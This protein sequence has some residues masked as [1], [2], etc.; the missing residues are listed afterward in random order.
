MAS[1]AARCQRCGAP[2]EIT[3]ETIVAVCSYCGYPNWT[4]QAYVY[5]IELVPSN[6]SKAREYFKHYLE[7]D[8]DMRKL[9]KDVRL[10]STELVYIPLYAAGVHAESRYYGVADVVLTRTRIVKRGK[11][12]EVETE[13]MTTTVEVSGSLEKDYDLPIIARRNVERSYTE[14]LAQYYMDKRPQSIPISQVNWEDVKGTVLASEIPSNDALTIARDEACDRLYKEVSEKMSDEA[15]E[16]AM[17]QHPGWMAS[18]VIWREKRIPCKAANRYLSPILL[19]PSII[20]I[21]TYKG[22]LYKAVFAGWDGEKVYSEEPLTPAQRA[23]YLTGEVLASGILG[24]GGAALA[25]LGGD[26][27]GAGV[28]LFLA[29]LAASYFLG[30]NLVKDV[31][32]ERGAGEE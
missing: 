12:T 13:T 3:P 26:Y 29:G 4:S 21:Y 11:E 5:P 30:R 1:G 2:L 18:K 7:T 19:V 16:K 8:P 25:A 14:P 23:L 6:P 32:V 28:I 24:G 17:A 27:T 22:G 10:K 15:R 31:R 9:A 20:A